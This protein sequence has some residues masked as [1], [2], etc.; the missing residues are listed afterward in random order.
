MQ[1]ALPESWSDPS[2]Y[3]ICNHHCLRARSLTIVPCETDLQVR[4]WRRRIIRLPRFVVTTNNE[5]FPVERYHL[6]NGW[7]LQQG[8]WLGN[9]S[10]NQVTPL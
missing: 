3:V 7:R 6:T 8:A 10:A 1:E 4:S 2:G 5:R 9:G